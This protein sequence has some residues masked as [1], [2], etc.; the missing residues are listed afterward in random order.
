M[1]KREPPPRKLT[2]EQYYALVIEPL[3]LELQ[4]V[5][6]KFAAIS[7]E[8]FPQFV[9]INAREKAVIA[10]AHEKSLQ[11]AADAFGLSKSQVG[12]DVKEARGAYGDVS[13]DVL[14]KLMFFIAGRKKGV[15]VEKLGARLGMNKRDSE[16]FVQ[17][18]GLYQAKLRRDPRA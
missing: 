16:E 10:V 15:P 17:K 14:V 2:Q 4:K 1:S 7:E 6:P 9:P 12:R 8:L 5:A 11:D 3:M 18:F 13:G